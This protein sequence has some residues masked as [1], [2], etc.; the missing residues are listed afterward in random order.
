MYLMLKLWFCELQNNVMNRCIIYLQILVRELVQPGLAMVFPS[1]WSLSKFYMCIMLAVHCCNVWMVLAI[2]SADNKLHFGA[3]HCTASLCHTHT[4]CWFRS[5]Q[6]S[7]HMCSGHA[8]GNNGSHD[9]LSNVITA[10]WYGRRLM[11]VLLRLLFQSV[12]PLMGCF[13]PAHASDPS[14]VIHIWVCQAP[15]CSS[16]GLDRQ[17]DGYLE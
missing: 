6:H 10:C 3:Y 9:R 2:F 15:D 13:I 12:K 17:K 14:Q 4:Y 7:V 16:S 5:A 1:Y 11:V 8:Y